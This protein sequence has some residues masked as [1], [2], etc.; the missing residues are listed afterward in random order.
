MRNFIFVILLFL[1]IALVILSFGEIETIVNT[2]QQ[3]NLWFVLLML[4]AQVAW[5]FVIGRMYRSVYHLLGMDDTT[6]NLSIV[7]AAANFINIVA[8]TAGMGGIA[9]FAA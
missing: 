3:G 5:F 7:A 9:L 8:P 4:L 2:L 6:V 1:G